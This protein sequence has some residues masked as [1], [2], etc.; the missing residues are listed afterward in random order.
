MPLGQY[1]LMHPEAEMNAQ[2]KTNLIAGLQATLGGEGGRRRWRGR[3]SLTP[4]RST[5]IIRIIEP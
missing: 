5:F 1:L 3:L 4:R 2:E